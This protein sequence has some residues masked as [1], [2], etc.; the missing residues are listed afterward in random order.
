[1]SLR[2]APQLVALP[3]S[4]PRTSS[5]FGRWLGRTVLRLG[6]WN[7]RGELPDLPRLMI[8]A[9]PHSSAWDGVWGLAAKLALGVD[10]RFMAKAELFVGPLGWLLRTVGGLPIDRAARRGMVGQMADR[11][12]AS[13]QLWLALTPEGTRRQVARWK[14]GFWHIARAADVPVVCAYFHYPERVIGIG[15]ALPTSA[16]LDA[17]MARV[18]EFYRPWIGRNRGTL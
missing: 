5:R 13:G 14:S 8:I 11:F 17:D 15:P 16:D 6:G 10:V 2:G 3:P 1:V 4:A 7:M 18:R 9:A 12:A